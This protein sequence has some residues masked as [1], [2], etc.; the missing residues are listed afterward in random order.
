MLGD[1]D[2]NLLPYFEGR[3][4]DIASPTRR[5]RGDRHRGRL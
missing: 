2:E 5:H 1:V 3:A 4:G